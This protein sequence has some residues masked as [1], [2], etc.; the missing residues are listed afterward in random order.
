T[1]FGLI[2]VEGHNHYLISLALQAGTVPVEIGWDFTGKSREE[3]E[4][5]MDKMTYHLHHD[6]SHYKAHYFCQ[7]VQDDYRYFASLVIA[8]AVVEK[9][10]AAFKKTKVDY[11]LAVKMTGDAEPVWFYELILGDALR[12][13]GVYYSA[14]KMGNNLSEKFIEDARRKLSRYAKRHPEL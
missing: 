11:P 8:K 3:V 14:S 7:M 9:G 12:G 10:Q 6:G 4:Q 5:L 13:A 2:L 1:D